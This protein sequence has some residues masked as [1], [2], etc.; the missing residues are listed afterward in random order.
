MSEFF[1]VN[2]SATIVLDD[3]TTSRNT[4]WSSE[5]IY[6][7]I[8]N[9]SG[10]GNGSG[11]GFKYMELNDVISLKSGESIQRDY[12]L[13]DKSMII[14]TVYLDVENGSTF[15]FSITDQIQN[16]FLLYNTG[17]VSHYTDSLFL[18]Y[19]DKD[20]ETSNKLH[21]HI[22]NGNLNAPVNLNLKILGLEVD[23]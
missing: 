5:Q 8:I 2:T 4:T 6:E 22:K 13:G 10:A 18:P 1:S 14:T 16:G 12:D 11:G 20:P 23:V 9:Y 3:S 19:K 21:T 17:R 7:A 15:E